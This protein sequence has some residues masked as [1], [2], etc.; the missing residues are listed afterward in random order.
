MWRFLNT[1]WGRRLES[2][3]AATLVALIS[4][5]GG[6]RNAE[7]DIPVTVL[8]TNV[9]GNVLAVAASTT[10]VQLHALLY[11]AT[12][13]PDCARP[14]TGATCWPDL[15]PPRSSLIVALPI[16]GGVTPSV[17]ATLGGARLTLVQPI[18]KA[19]GGVMQPLSPLGLVAIPLNALPKAVL[20]L[21]APPWDGPDRFG[22][23]AIVDLRDPLP[24]ETDLKSTIAF[25]TAASV[26]A[27]RDAESRLNLKVPQYS[28]INR[29]GVRH[30]DDNSLGCA[31]VPASRHDLVSGYIFFVAPVGS[32]PA[33]ELEYH[34]AAERTLFCGYSH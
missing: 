22:G 25:L 23:A 8:A 28:G 34:V 32:G 12:D 29:V 21:V 10:L 6:P 13:V 3:C 5:C 33:R 16:F 31:G 19:V 14:P 30:W 24:N 15:K 20:T 27:F 4:G 2:A 7:T 11:L 1:A 26:V 9:T 18:P 17:K